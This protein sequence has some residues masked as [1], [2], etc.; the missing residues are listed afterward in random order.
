MLVLLL[1]KRPFGAGMQSGQHFVPWWVF[2]FLSLK[3]RSNLDV[4]YSI[5]VVFILLAVGL[6]GTVQ[7][8]IYNTDLYLECNKFF[9]GGGT[10][11]P[12]CK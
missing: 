8:G 11:V 4:F 5:V 3:A 7:C 2:W 6:H 10:Q 12:L 1:C 9:M